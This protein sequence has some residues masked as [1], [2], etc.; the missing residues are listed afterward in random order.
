MPLRKALDKL[1]DMI[2]DLSSLHVQTYTG[3][4]AVNLENLDDNQRVMD[5]VRDAVASAADTDGT[6]RLVAET[7]VQLDGDAY[8][9][10]TDEAAPQAALELHGE[11]V[12]AGLETRLGLIEL[13]RSVF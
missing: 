10:L 13:V 12:K 5:R 3:R 4:V 8:N 1:D 6:V 2:D 11:S 9:F 7:Y